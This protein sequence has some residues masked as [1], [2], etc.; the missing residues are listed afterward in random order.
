MKE[1]KYE[2]FMN[3]EAQEFF[4][5]KIIEEQ[6][7]GLAV[8]GHFIQLVNGKTYLPS[9]GDIFTKYDDGTIS[10]KTIYR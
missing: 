2:G 6:R 1:F 8:I 7:D 4:K 10:V 9:K 5:G 3:S